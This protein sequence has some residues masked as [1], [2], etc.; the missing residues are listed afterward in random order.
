MSLEDFGLNASR[1][2]AGFAGGVVHTFVF[3][4]TDPLAQIGSVVTGTLTANFLGQA[5]AHYI[6]PWLGEGGS[7]FIVGLSAMAICQGIVAMAQ[8]R[9]RSPAPTSEKERRD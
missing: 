1:L 3:K 4:Q 7:A 9:I 8:T 6:G 2:I 5:A